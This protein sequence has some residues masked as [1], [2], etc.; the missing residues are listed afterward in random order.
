MIDKE[1]PRRVDMPEPGYYLTR[2]I[3]NG[4]PVGA[5]I[6]QHE[7]GQ[8]SVMRDGVWEGPSHNPW[9]LPLMHTV[10]IAKRT[11]AEDVQYRIGMRKWAELYAP[12]HPAANPRKPID[13]DGPVIF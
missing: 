3:R 7:D 4:P 8:W 9:S 13:L 1:A 11:T 12:T 6:V 2:L 10:F 5:Q